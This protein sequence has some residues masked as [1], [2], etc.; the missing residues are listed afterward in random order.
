ML[1]WK[2]DIFRFFCYNIVMPF[3]SKSAQEHLMQNADLYS[4]A[5]ID[6]HDPPSIPFFLKPT[7]VLR[8]FQMPTGSMPKIRPHLFY[9]ELPG[10]N[11]DSRKNRAHRFP[12]VYNVLLGDKIRQEATGSRME[13]ARAFAGSLAARPL[14]D[15]TQRDFQR[16]VHNASIE[17]AGGNVI[18][19]GDVQEILSV[20]E[21]TVEEWVHSDVLTS[22]FGPAGRLLY[23][24]EIKVTW[25]IPRDLSE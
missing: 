24:D 3:I 6:V 16:R 22:A 10:S 14:I 21:T 12:F 20:G 18:G 25:H 13:A 8:L 5:G 11:A 19:R 4:S 1:P 7:Q 23:A 15:M 9:A 2:M 17:A